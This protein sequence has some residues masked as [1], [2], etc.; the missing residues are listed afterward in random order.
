MLVDLAGSEKVRKTGAAGIRLREA[1][2]INLSLLEL[3]NVT[4]YYQCLKIR[5]CF[6]GLNLDIRTFCL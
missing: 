2:A 3:G 1:Q 6:Q 4:Y 5:I